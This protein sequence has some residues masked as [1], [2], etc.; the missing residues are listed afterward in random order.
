M[1]SASVLAGTL[2]GTLWQPA[3]MLDVLFTVVAVATV[4]RSGV[5]DE[6]RAVG[7]ECAARPRPHRCCGPAQDWPPP[8]LAGACSSSRWRHGQPACQVQD[9]VHGTA[10]SRARRV[11]AQGGGWRSG[12]Y[13]SPYSARC[14]RA[15]PSLLRSAPTPRAAH[16]DVTCRVSPEDL[17]QR[18]LADRGLLRL[19]SGQLSTEGVGLTARRALKRPQRCWGTF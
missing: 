2:A 5:G 17:A 8:G 7:G 13:R 18:S 19:P 9:T 6:Q 1:A 16:V 12:V 4:L 3:V 15:A 14:H 11:G 10:P